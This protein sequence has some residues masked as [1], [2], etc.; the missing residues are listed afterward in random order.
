MYIDLGRALTAYEALYYNE[1]KV[2]RGDAECLY[3]GN[4][5]KDADEL[6]FDEKREWF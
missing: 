3:A 1:Q 6:D 4:F 2:L 5:L